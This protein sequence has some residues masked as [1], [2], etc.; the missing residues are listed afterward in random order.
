MWAFAKFLF[1]ERLTGA[2]I[3][4]TWSLE[5][6]FFMFFLNQIA[7]SPSRALRNVLTACADGVT[8]LFDAKTG[9]CQGDF[10]RTGDFRGLG[11]CHFCIF[12]LWVHPPP[13]FKVDTVNLFIFMKGPILTLTNST[14]TWWGGSP[15]YGHLCHLFFFMVSFEGQTPRQQ[16]MRLYFE[17]GFAPQIHEDVKFD[18][19]LFGFWDPPNLEPPPSTCKTNMWF[20]NL[21][22]LPSLA[23]DLPKVLAFQFSENLFGWSTPSTPHFIIL[24]ASSQPP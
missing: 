24:M 7:D 10:R 13:W 1:A 19:I 6:R 23:G 4:S 15:I 5:T 14:V 8:R 11:L 18:M 16:M 22:S 3:F 2:L 9:E 20:L 21:P 17:V 12:L